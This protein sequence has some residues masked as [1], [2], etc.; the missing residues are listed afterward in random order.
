[1]LHPGSKGWIRKYFSLMENYE[2]YLDKYPG[3]ILCPEELIYGYL[4]PTGIMYGY[5]TSLVFLEDEY[6]SKWTSEETFKV[7]LLEGLILVDHIHTGKF[8]HASLEK[9]LEKFV[10]FYESTEL[11]KAKRSW[12]NFKGLTIYEKLES[13]IDQRVDIKASFSNKLWTSY[14]YNSLLFHD[15]LLYYEYMQ[16]ADVALLCEKRAEVLLDMVKVVASAAN[17]DGEPEEEEEKIFEVFIAS[18]DLDDERHQVAEEFFKNRKTL[19]DISF[20]YEK[21]WLLCRYI[22]EIAILTV[23]SDH[24]VVDSEH[25]FLNKLVEKLGIEEEEKDKSFVAIQSFVNKNQNKIPFLQ[26][27]G[28]IRMLMSGATDR[29]AKILGRSKDKLAA[30][31]S[32]SKELVGLIAKS[33]KSDLSKDEREKVKKQFK[34]LARTIPSLGLFLLPGGSLLLP[35]VLKIIPDLVPSAFRVNEV[36]DEN[37]E[38]QKKEDK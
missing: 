28:D 38:A 6:L 18:A 17:V 33:T 24:E 19:N 4:Q 10:K 9:S 1:M 13:I 37:E 26:D 25:E 32:Q 15:L 35:I 31:L 29:W 7:L 2:Q 12:L 36:E 22:L 3:T 11:E 27:K 8:D 20:K 21:S 34:D 16:G 14:L 23:W 5:P 30:E